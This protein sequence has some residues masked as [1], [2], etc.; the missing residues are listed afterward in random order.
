MEERMWKNARV[1]PSGS[2][3]QRIALLAAYITRT[4]HFMTQIREAAPDIDALNEVMQWTVSPYWE[5]HY[6]FG[7]SSRAKLE[8]VTDHVRSIVTINAVVPLLYAY[9]KQSGKDTMAE[10][11]VDIVSALQP[12]HNR[13]TR[14][15]EAAGIVPRNAFESQALTHLGKEYCAREGCLRCR[16]GCKELLNKFKEPVGVGQSCRQD[17]EKQVYTQL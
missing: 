12:E 11:A 16:F 1:R 14:R 17:V 10:Q 2:P 7:V 6:N 13:Y 5:E 3:A 15:F 9:G 4:P 8:G